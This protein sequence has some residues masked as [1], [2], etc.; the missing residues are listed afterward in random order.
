MGRPSTTSFTILMPHQ[1]ADRIGPRGAIVGHIGHYRLAVAEPRLAGSAD[2]L[3][4]KDRGNSVARRPARDDLGEIDA[5]VRG[6]RCSAKWRRTGSP[7]LVWCGGRAGR[8]RQERAE[9]TAVVRRAV[10]TGCGF[11]SWRKIQARTCSN[12]I[13]QAVITPHTHLRQLAA[14]KTRRRRL[15]RKAAGN[16]RPWPSEECLRR[17]VFRKLVVPRRGDIVGHLAHD[18]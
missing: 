7:V 18:D 2:E 14:P 16:G 1:V 9:R 13:D 12:S 11:G 5:E 8:A 15:Y 6:N 17:A 4:G 3:G 10:W